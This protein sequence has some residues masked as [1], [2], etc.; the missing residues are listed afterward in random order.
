[1]GLEADPRAVRPGGM[2]EREGRARTHVHL[3]RLPCPRELVAT[4]DQHRREPVGV[5]ERARVDR[6]DC[7]GEHRIAR[8]DHDESLGREQLAEHAGEGR[9]PRLPWPVVPTQALEVCERIRAG[10]EHLG[11]PVEGRRDRVGQ[12]EVRDRDPV[13]GGDRDRDRL[14][15]AIADDLAARDLDE[16]VVLGL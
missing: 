16:I 12:R 14:G 10:A 11:E 4:R 5:R 2:E 15:G 6:R 1:M 13:V 7:R 3:H 9:G 8:I